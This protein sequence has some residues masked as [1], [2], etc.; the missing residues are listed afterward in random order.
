M[1]VST[2]LQAFHAIDPRRRT[3]ARASA[4]QNARSVAERDDD[5]PVAHRRSP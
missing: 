5:P 1:P 2:S 4:L 3:T